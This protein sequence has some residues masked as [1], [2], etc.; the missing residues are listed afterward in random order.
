VLETHIVMSLLI[1]SL[2]LLLMLHLVSFT[3]QTIADMVLAHERIA[4]GLDALVMAHILINVIIPCIGTVLLLEG[5][6]LALS[7]DTWTVHVF[8]V[9]V[10]VSLVSHDT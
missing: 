10:H 1:L 5:H 2:I 8:L 6:T 3:D 4:L 7:Q 9:V